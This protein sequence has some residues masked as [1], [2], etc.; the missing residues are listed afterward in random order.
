[1]SDL[2]L[3]KLHQFFTRKH[4]FLALTVCASLVVSSIIANKEKGIQHMVDTHSTMQWFPNAMIP[5][6]T[7]GISRTLTFQKIFL[8]ASMIAF[9]K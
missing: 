4:F 2:V 5:L 9:Q 7:L 1:M 6:A 8:F 3:H